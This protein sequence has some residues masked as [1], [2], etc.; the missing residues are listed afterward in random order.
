MTDLRDELSALRAQLAALNARIYRLEQRAGFGPDSAKEPVPVPQAPVPRAPA[1]PGPGQPAESSRMHPTAPTFSVA[2]AKE[3][4][5][6]EGQIGKLWLNRIGIIAI[7]TGVSYF[8]KYAFDNGWIGPAG[9]VALGLLVGIGLIFWSERFRARGHAPFSYSL[10]AVGI[11][12]LYL[13]L[14]GAFQIYHLVPSAVAFVAMIVV[15]ASTITLALAQDAEILAAFAIIGG[16]STPIL[17]STGQNHEVVLFTYVALLDLAMLIVDTLKPWRRLLVGSFTG[18]AIL[19]IGWFAEYYSKDQQI[20]TTL[21]T[22]LFA[23]IFAVIPLLTP[24][25]PS[26]WLSGFSVTLTL[27]PLVN[28]A[29]VFLALNAMCGNDTLTWYALALAAAYLSLSSQFKRRVGSDPNVVK[30]INMLHIAIA[31]AFIT[32]AIPLKLNSHWITLGWLVESAVLL[33]VSLR[34]QTNFLRYFAG[35]TLTLGIIRLLIFDNFR[36]DTLIFNARFATYLVAIAILGGIVA[37]AEHFA[38]EGEQRVI[39]LAT[40]LFNLLALIALTLEASDYFQRQMTPLYAAHNGSYGALHQVELARRFSYSLLWLAYG[41]GLMLFG[42]RRRSAFV[43]W[44]ALVLIAFTI[45]KVFLF[46]VSELQQGY[47]I[48]SFIA[49]GAVLMGISYVYH[50]D[51]LKLSPHAPQKST[52]GR[53]A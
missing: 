44:Q 25:T 16:F 4:E 6:L 14:W 34:T 27:L 19:Y 36:V 53:S 37:A 52:Q 26:R 11:G 42:F 17:L 33:Y 24:L 46:D 29:A 20:T 23:A 51:W 2:P 13:S 15:T 48:I 47:R 43:R 40:V 32:I 5:E 12:T 3:E 30:T 1:T 18:T 31:V 10:K 21:F 28:A 41:A 7:L 39:Q 9:R 22:L 38:S 49:L 8:I 35:T 50:R 45:G